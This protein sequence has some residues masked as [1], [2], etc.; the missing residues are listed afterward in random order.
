MLFSLRSLKKT[1]DFNVAVFFFS[2]N[3]QPVP[4]SRTAA[5]AAATPFLRTGFRAMC[6]RLTHKVV[7]L[8]NGAAKKNTEMQHQF[9]Q[10]NQSE[11]CRLSFTTIDHCSAISFCQPAAAASLILLDKPRVELPIKVV[12][13]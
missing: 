13:V 12:Q 10:G 7:A 11:N 4:S 8:K 9:Q 6:C 3:H 2:R 5:A 1:H